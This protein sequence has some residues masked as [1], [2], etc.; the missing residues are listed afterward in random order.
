MERMKTH[1][2]NHPG[3]LP[4][5]RSYLSLQEAFE[6]AIS[7][8]V[9]LAGRRSEPME[10]RAEGDAAAAEPSAPHLTGGRRRTSG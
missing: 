6:Q 7:L 10:P 2:S 9:A 3:P 4:L 5:E 8:E 1:P